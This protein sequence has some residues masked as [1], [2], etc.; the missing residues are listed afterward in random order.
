[1]YARRT[2][3]RSCVLLQADLMELSSRSVL[4]SLAPA[5]APLCCYRAPC[6]AESTPLHYPPLTP[7]FDPSSRDSMS[8]VKGYRFTFGPW[9]ISMGG[10][11]FG[12]TVRKEVAF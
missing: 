7:S 4:H 2:T 8:A 11:P 10:D 3:S 1:M 12:P 6:S 5:R 9:N